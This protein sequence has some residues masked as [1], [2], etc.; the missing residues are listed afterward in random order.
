MSNIS[1]RIVA[2]ALEALEGNPEGLRY[3]ELVRWVLT[4]DGTFKKNTVHGKV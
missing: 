3:S 1:N 2:A 4:H